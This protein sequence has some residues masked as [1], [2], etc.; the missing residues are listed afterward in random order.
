MVQTARD[1]S[2]VAQ[3]TD[4]I[5]HTVAKHTIALHLRIQIRPVKFIAVLQI[6]ALTD[7]NSA[8]L[9]NPALREVFMQCRQNLFVFC[10][11]TALIPKSI[12][13][14]NFSFSLF[15]F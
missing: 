6:D 3:N 1:Y 9:V 11:R 2:T 7:P 4:M 5:T 15:S 14:Q 8:T 10:I 12:G 13:D